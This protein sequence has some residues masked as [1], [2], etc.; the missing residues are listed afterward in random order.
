LPLGVHAV[1]A[2]FVFLATGYALAT[3]A[4]NN[5]DEPAHFGYIKQIA[6]RG[7]LPTLDPGDWDAA[8]L[9]ALKARKFVDPRDVEGIDYEAH[10]PPLYYAFAA[11]IYRLTGGL[12]LRDRVMALR[13]LSILFAAALVYVTGY[14]ALRL[15]PGGASSATLA[16]AFVA[17]LPMHTA[18]A[19]AIN[20]DALANLLGGALLVVAVLG[21]SSG[22]TP[23]LTVAV[24]LIVGAAFLTKTTLYVLIALVGVALALARRVHRTTVN[25]ILAALAVAAVPGALWLLRNSSL[26][27]WQDPL[28]AARHDQVVV[29]QLRTADAG[30]EVVGGMLATLRASFWGDF[31]WMGIPLHEPIYQAYQVLLVLALLGGGFAL[32][33][34]HPED[35]S[36]RGIALLLGAVLAVGLALLGYNLTFVQPQGRYLFPALAAIGVLVALGLTSL[37]RGEHLPP[38]L[39]WLGLSLIV[40]AA[41]ALAIETAA[42]WLSG[43]N[44]R[45]LYLFA[46]VLAAAAAV[47]PRYRP[48]WREGVGVATV[49]T[50]MAGADLALL[51]G[52]VAPAFR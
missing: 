48:H 45:M 49:I 38:R 29:G 11:P 26:Y 41:S 35:R 40:V 6:E 43:G 8:R 34:P 3:P 31:G 47:L 30:P 13:M 39:R 18:M 4:W 32:M 21:V 33:G 9:E 2:V 37:I 1:V 36:I 20:N 12:S 51:L 19:A 28:G 27:G 44:R 24:G 25:A 50:A 42:P 10:Q 14:L 15:R 46:V 16:A 52:V 22:L 7:Q 23:R 5:P 17:F